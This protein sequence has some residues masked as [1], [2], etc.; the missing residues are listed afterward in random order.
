[1]LLIVDTNRIIAALLRDSASRGILFSSE[2]RFMSLT[3]VGKEIAKYAS[4]LM[5]RSGY[6]QETFTALLG[7]ICSRM[8][9]FDDREIQMFM[10]EAKGILDSIDPKDTPF[11]AL[12]LAV[13]NDGI[14]SEDKHFEQQDRVNVWKTKDLLKLLGLP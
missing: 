2:L 1:M 8:R 14:W 3:L 7:K 6:N 13:E 11:I 9:F 12:A 10:A 4:D 5:E